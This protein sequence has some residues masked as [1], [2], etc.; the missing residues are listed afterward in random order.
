[1]RQAR[2]VQQHGYDIGFKFIPR[3]PDSPYL[4]LCIGRFNTTEGLGSGYSCTSRTEAFTSCLYETIE[5]AL[6]IEQVAFWQ[7]GSVRAPRTHLNERA[8]SLSALAGFSAQQREALHL[9]NI[10]DPL[11]WSHGFS[12][13]DGEPLLIPTQLVSSR[14][15]TSRPKNE[16]L[17]RE[18]NSNGLASHATKEGALC[19]GM[20]EIIERDAFMITFHN[21]ISAPTIPHKLVTHHDTQA[22]L[23]DLARY[24]LEAAFVLLPTDMPAHVVACVIR[25]KHGVGPAFALGAKAHAESSRAVHGA[26][27]ESIGVW[28]L[29]RH[30]GLY[31]KKAPPFVQMDALARIAYWAQAENA[32]Q[33]DWLTAGEPL[34]ALP[35]KKFPHA[36][37]SIARL[38]QKQGVHMAALRISPP[39]F[40]QLGFHAYMTVSPELQPINL[41][42]NP[43]YLGGNRL[44]DVPKK[45]G[46]PIQEEPPDYPHPFP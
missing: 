11:L 46:Y 42:A 41:N 38:A 4:A 17:L 3:F 35:R 1:M 13:I 26:L 6:W 45:I 2:A 7:E 31:R 10:A 33:L 37:R 8:L 20:W 40:E 34:T 16:P 5:R 39:I 24:N 28:H 25:D 14:Y 12:L 9:G 32:P 29:A 21:A 27:V 19:A 22:I 44:R 15:A 43:P 23:E 36:S 30:L 18:C